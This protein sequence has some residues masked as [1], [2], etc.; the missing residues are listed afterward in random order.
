MA[1][2]HLPECMIG[3]AHTCSSGRELLKDLW[4]IST[5]LVVL[6]WQACLPSHIRTIDGMAE[7]RPVPVREWEGEWQWVLTTTKVPSR[8][9]TGPTYPLSVQEHIIVSGAAQLKSFFN[10]HFRVDS[11]ANMELPFSVCLRLMTAKPSWRSVLKSTLILKSDI[12]TICLNY[13]TL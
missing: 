11:E 3:R 12:L 4:T 1:K 7:R 10:Q 9:N 13:A 5:V 8:S 2:T 6:S